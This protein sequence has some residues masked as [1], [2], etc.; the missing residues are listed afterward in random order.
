MTLVSAKSHVKPPTQTM[1]HKA[2][3]FTLFRGNLPT[4]G[5]NVQKQPIAV[6]IFET[7][8]STVALEMYTLIQIILK[9]ESFTTITKS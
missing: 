2:T 4:N 7:V 6:C 1:C 3:A 9:Q 5:F 8:E